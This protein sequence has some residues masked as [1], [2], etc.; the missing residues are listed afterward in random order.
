MGSRTS[1]LAVPVVL[2][3]LLAGLLL[4]PSALAAPPPGGLR[5]A[6]VVPADVTAGY[7]VYDRTTRRTVAE[8]APRARFRSASL[9][10]LLIALDLTQ[11]RTSVSSA[12]RALLD[13]MLR[14]S[15]DDAASTLWVRQG[16]EQ[17][18][19]RM[20]RLIGLADTAPPTDRRYWGYTAVSAA[21]VAT[22]YNYLLDRATPFQR[23]LIVGNLERATQCAADGFDQSFGIPRAVAGTRAVKQ[24][25]SGYGTAPA[26]PCVEG[27]Q[28]TPP[29]ALSGQAAEEA[30][31]AVADSRPATLAAPALDLSRRALHTSGLVDARRRVVVVLTLS[32]KTTSFETQSTTITNITRTLHDEAVAAT[33]T[34]TTTTPTT[35][36]TAPPTTTTA[37]PTT[38]TTTAPSTDPIEVYARANAAKLGPAT[39]AAYAVPGGRGRDYRD[40]TVYWSAATGAHAVGGPTLTK[41]RA[42]GATGS[43]LGFPVIDTTPTPDGRGRYT[44]FA[45]SG[46]SIYLNPARGAAYAVYGAI[47]ERWASLGWERSRLGYPTRD[48]Y[49]VTGGRRS[50]FDQGTITWTQRTGA[51][52]VA[53]R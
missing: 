26:R 13:S 18:V 7:V 5:A 53:Y 2:A 20:V 3:G 28:D 14:S 38:T 47:R 12:D 22:V 33:P 8:S 6:P 40:A 44:H 21:D 15:D 9:V 51:I 23:D 50:D 35:T 42:L 11:G 34:T 48:E 49:A 25:W 43:I 37:P 36:T 31:Q 30:P 27:R 41:Y 32:P 17:V 46:G 24:G 16:Y 19:V 4:A 1:R 52:S 39:G 29:D 45:G 10:K